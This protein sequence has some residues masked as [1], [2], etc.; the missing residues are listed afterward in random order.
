MLHVQRFSTSLKLVTFM[1]FQT[2]IGS[3]APASSRRPRCFPAGRASFSAP[4][5]TALP[6]TKSATLS[7]TAGMEA[8]RR[9]RARVSETFALE[10]CRPHRRPEG[11][12]IEAPI[13]AYNAYPLDELTQSR[14]TARQS[15][16]HWSRLKWYPRSRGIKFRLS[17]SHFE[18]SVCH[19]VKYRWWYGFSKKIFTG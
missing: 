5:G 15:G 16:D 13:N 10:F 11:A 7:T 1:M 2:C 8:T 14:I 19:R 3:F 17:Q 6:S 9:V 18:I 12:F 4:T